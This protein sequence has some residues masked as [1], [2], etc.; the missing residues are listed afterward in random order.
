MLCAD[1][2][3]ERKSNYPIDRGGNWDLFYKNLQ[4]YTT[5]SDIADAMN[6]TK[7]SR[8]YVLEV[9]RGRKMSWPVLGFLTERANFNKVYGVEGHLPIT[10]TKPGA[11]R[12]QKED[13]MEKL[14]CTLTPKEVEEQ[15]QRPVNEHFTISYPII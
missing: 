12:N 7:K 15:R 13:M 5:F 11:M 14:I 10:I 8:A 1:P 9:L 2:P 3:S 6:H 4:Q